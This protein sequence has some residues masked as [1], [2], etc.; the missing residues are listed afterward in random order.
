M[1]VRTWGG[2]GGGSVHAGDSVSVRVCFS[3]CQ[4]Y[5]ALYKYE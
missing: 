1:C 3:A 4:F 2:G 5:F